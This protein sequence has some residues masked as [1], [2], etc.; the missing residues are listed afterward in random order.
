MKAKQA[1]VC[2]TCG[3]LNRPTW[4][5]CARCNESLE[6]AQTAE[7]PAGVEPVV[8]EPRPSSLPANGIALLGLL[9]LVALAVAAWRHASQ[10]ASPERPDPNLF[11]MA[12]PAADLPTAPPPAGPGAADYEAGRLLLNSGDLSGGVARLAAAVAANPD[13]AEYQS[14]YAHALWR[15]GDKEGSLAVHAEAARLEPRFQAQ[16]ARALD[17]AGRGADAARQYED[18]LVRSPE[19]AN[20]HEDLGRLLFRGGDYA[21]AASHL[22]QA[23]QARPDDPVLA[24]ELAYSLDQSGDRAQAVAVYQKVLKQAPQ[25][26]VTRGLLAESLIQEGK[27]DEALTLLQEGLKATPSAP[28]LQRQMGSVLERSGQPAAAAAAYRAYA[29]LAPNAP[30]ARE[31]TA[32]AARLEAAGGKP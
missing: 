16:Y 22:Q 30:D 14:I 5:Y 25:A 19:A 1:V 11:T 32:R 6:G 28:L 4:D 10:A 9:A 27:K 31:M 23:V 13:N 8:G 12:S 24:Q 18:I 20:V 15:S 3:A 7:G 2:P 21:K 17:M 29:R 26:V